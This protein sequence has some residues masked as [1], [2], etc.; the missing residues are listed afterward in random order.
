MAD[1]MSFGTLLNV[2]FNGAG[3]VF[4]NNFVC[5]LV[6]LFLRL[7]MSLEWGCV[8]LKFKCLRCLIDY[9]FWPLD[10]G[11]AALG[12]RVMGM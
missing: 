10:Y 12:T 2:A 9:R 11:T 4:V 7:A 1:G 5:V 6:A 3:L 8:R